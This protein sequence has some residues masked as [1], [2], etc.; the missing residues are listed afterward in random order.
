MIGLNLNNAEAYGGALYHF[1]THG[2]F[3]S[4][5]FLIAGMLTEMYHTRKISEI[6]GLWQHSKILSISLIIAILSITGSPFLSGGYSKH[7]IIHSS[8]GILIPML[9]KIISAGT[10]ISFIKFFKVIFS[11][12]GTSPKKNLETN[13]AAVISI[14]AIMCII[15][16]LFGDRFVTLVTGY[17]GVYSASMQAGDLASYILSYCASYFVYR[18]IIKDKKWI[19]KLRGFELGFNSISLSILS[20]F[21]MSLMILKLSI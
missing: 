21:V 10:M 9:L 7:L 4:L 15:L 18:M 1:L 13:E 17:V 2:I 5:L 3:K 6:K 11:S 12:P 14:M 8:T 20:F 19:A 16:G